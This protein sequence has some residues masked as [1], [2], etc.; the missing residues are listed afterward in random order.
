VAVTERGLAAVDLGISR[1][2]FEQRLGSRGYEPVAFDQARTA[3]AIRQLDEYLRGE[4]HS[5]DLPVDW[6][7]LTLFQQR[8]YQLTCAIPY[9]QVITYGEIARQLGNPAAARAVG[10]AQATNPMPLV[11]PCHRVLGSDGALHGY[12]AGEGLKTKEWLLALESGTG[13]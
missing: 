10:R 6:S 8:A 3:Q 7:S 5:F 11:I 4:R 13:I 9:G 12:G 2:S 1:E